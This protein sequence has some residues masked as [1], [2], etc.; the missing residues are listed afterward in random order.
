MYCLFQ[1]FL[2]A[3]E[4]VHNSVKVSHSTKFFI[5]ELSRAEKKKLYPS[6]KVFSFYLAYMF[7][8]VVKESKLASFL[9]SGLLVVL[10]DL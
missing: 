2:E 9:S 8:S 6:K 7:S 1:S 4:R 3:S 5:S 10:E